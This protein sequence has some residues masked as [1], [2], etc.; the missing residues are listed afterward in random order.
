MQKAKQIK[1][2]VF[3][4]TDKMQI[5][6]TFSFVRDARQFLGKSG[7]NLII[8]RRKHERDENSLLLLYQ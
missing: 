7:H 2:S 1:K 4:G 8:A 5:L 6:F 3:C